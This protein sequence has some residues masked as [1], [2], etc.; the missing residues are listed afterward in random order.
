MYVYKITNEC[1]LPI[2]IG[3]SNKPL[4]R[5]REHYNDA[6]SKKRRR[7]KRP[8]YAKLRKLREIRFDPPRSIT[9]SNGCIIEYPHRVVGTLPD[10]VEVIR[11]NNVVIY[12]PMPEDM[13]LMFEAFMINRYKNILKNLISPGLHLKPHIL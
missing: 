11:I 1:N 8:N 13:S 6:F 3:K 9:F 7:R 12:G 5:L 4:L 10:D 2:Y